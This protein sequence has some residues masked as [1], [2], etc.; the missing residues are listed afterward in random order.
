MGTDLVVTPP[1]GLDTISF[2]G[3]TGSLNVYISLNDLRVYNQVLTDAE[4]Q[5][6][7]TL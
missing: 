3:S 6:L 1:T 4:L 7:T 2:N 5:A